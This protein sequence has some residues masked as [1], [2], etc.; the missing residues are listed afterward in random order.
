MSFECVFWGF[1]VICFIVE[2]KTETAFEESVFKSDEEAA[3]ATD[4]MF[5]PFPLERV[6]GD[7]FKRYFF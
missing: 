7:V 3:T 6:S 1:V 4:F 2:I 5:V